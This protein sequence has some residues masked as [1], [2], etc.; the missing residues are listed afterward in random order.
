M[1]AAA[2]HLG[3]SKKTQP[4]PLEFISS[5]LLGGE[6]AQGRHQPQ[7]PACF[8]SHQTHRLGP[9]T[10]Q[11]APRASRQ[12]RQPTQQALQP[13]SQNRG[14]SAET[15]RWGLRGPIPGPGGWETE[16][17]TKRCLFAF[18]WERSTFTRL[19]KGIHDP[20]KVKSKP[21]PK[22]GSGKYPRCRSW[23]EGFLL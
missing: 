5:T 7:L 4:P 15:Q 17:S 23:L 8:L 19:S 18:L 1:H 3:H 11:A 10:G 14:S 13:W 12:S 2:A 20:R 6:T 16:G 9:T 21:S 22:W